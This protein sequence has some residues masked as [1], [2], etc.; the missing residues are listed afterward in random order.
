MKK[1]MLMMLLA[2]LSLA[3]IAQ[4]KKDSKESTV[5]KAE[6]KAEPKDTLV[7]DLSKY[8]YV[9]IKGS[10]DVHDFKTEI[11][12]FVPF[13]WIIQ[14]YDFFDNAKSGLSKKDI[15]NLQIPLYPYFEN[16]MKQLQ[17]QQAQQ[18]K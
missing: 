3:T 9:A 16:Y 17:A 4:V 2:A 12:L 1:T 18:K 11:A 15:Q 5:L 14:S 7:I 8:R 10:Q 6:L 13:D